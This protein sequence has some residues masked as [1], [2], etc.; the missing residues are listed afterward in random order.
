MKYEY[1]PC[2]FFPPKPAHHKPHPT[3]DFEYFIGHINHC[4]DRLHWNKY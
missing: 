2:D 3:A 4:T 1:D